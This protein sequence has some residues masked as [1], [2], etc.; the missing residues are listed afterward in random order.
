MERYDM[1]GEFWLPL[2]PEA[3]GDAVWR[4][5]VQTEMRKHRERWQLLPPAFD[6]G[7]SLDIAILGAGTNARDVDNLAHDVLGA[8]EEVYCR[9]WR[10]TVIGYRAYR[11]PAE[12]PGVRVRAMVGERMRQLADAL[13]AARLY[14][15]ARGPR[16]R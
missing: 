5:T 7:L 16:E 14:V 15:I 8:F 11:C 10:G 13:D 2:P 6:A 12:V 1:P 4:E 9:G 3:R